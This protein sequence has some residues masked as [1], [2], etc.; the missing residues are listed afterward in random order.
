MR[1]FYVFLAFMVFGC[2]GN[3]IDY[4]DPSLNMSFPGYS[5]SFRGD[6]QLTIH[7][8]GGAPVYFDSAFFSVDGKTVVVP[9][10]AHYGYDSKMQIDKNFILSLANAGFV[11]WRPSNYVDELF[12]F[13]VEQLRRV[14]E[15]YK[16]IE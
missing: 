15:Y 13:N 2:A 4:S 14:E 10:G 11:S 8:I 6:S 7:K 5:L 3:Q 1:A 9:A 12:T 16:F